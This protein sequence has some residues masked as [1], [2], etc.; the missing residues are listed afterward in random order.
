MNINWGA[1]YG[2]K[3]SLHDS[4]QQKDR[5]IEQRILKLNKV[6]SVFFSTL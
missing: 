3:L 4:K 2:S 6:K 1:I 5:E